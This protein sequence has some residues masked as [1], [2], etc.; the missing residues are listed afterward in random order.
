M[1]LEPALKE[2]KPFMNDQQQFTALPAKH[3]KKL[4]LYYCF[5]DKPESSRIYTESEIND[6]LDW[7]AIFHDAA[8]LR[9]ELYNKRLLNRTA[10]GARYWKGEDILPFE[11]FL[12]KYC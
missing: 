1:N 11:A 8:T 5:S 6:L 10:D 4:A 2:L 9:R 3:R 7:W 12:A